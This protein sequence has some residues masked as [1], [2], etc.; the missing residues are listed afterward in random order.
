MLYYDEGY[1]AVCCYVLDI[2]AGR[3][4][5]SASLIDYF[6]DYNE[7]PLRIVFDALQP[8]LTSAI[9]DH[10]TGEDRMRNLTVIH[11]ALRHP[12][13]PVG[14]L[15]AACLSGNVRYRTTAV[16]HPSCPV[17][18][19]IEEWLSRPPDFGSGVLR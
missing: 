18:Y 7:T 16:Q 11:A 14:L 3:T 19:Q 12:G 1:H 4:T 5:D 17:E 2:E 8:L 6:N 15:E 10:N 13:C 9:K